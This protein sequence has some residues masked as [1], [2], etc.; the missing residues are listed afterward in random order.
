ML[1]KLSSNVLLKSLNPHKFA[2]SLACELMSLGLVVV[3]TTL[4]HQTCFLHHYQ[5]T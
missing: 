3:N 4:F 1:V 2:K 5:K